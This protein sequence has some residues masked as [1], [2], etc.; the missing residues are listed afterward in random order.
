M[1][2]YA[3]GPGPLLTQLLVETKCLTY[4]CLCHC[5]PLKEPHPA[6]AIPTPLAD[7]Q[8]E[9]SAGAWAAPSAQQPSWV[10]APEPD[11][12]PRSRGLLGA[13]KK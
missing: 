4:K 6:E 9:T 2:V 8:Y 5:R 10:G 1:F 11:L 12:K 3:F 7:P 13:F